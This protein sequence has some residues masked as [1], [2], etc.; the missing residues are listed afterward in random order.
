[1]AAAHLGQDRAVQKALEALDAGR[2]RKDEAERQWRARLVVSLVRA[3]AR[4]RVDQIVEDLRI[5]VLGVLDE[6]NERR[7]LGLAAGLRAKKVQ[8][9]I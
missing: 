2:E 7:M 6:D 1:M 5:E 4:A 9:W 8:G 3:H